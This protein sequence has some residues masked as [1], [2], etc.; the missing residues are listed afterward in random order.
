VENELYLVDTLRIPK[1]SPAGL[2]LAG[3][4]IWLNDYASGELYQISIE[5]GEI[6]NSL[7]CPGVISGLTWDG[8][9]LWQTRMDEDWLQRINPETLDFDLTLPLSEG[10]RLT[11]VAWDGLQL[12]VILQAKGT[13]FAIDAESGNSNKSIQVPVATTAIDIDNGYIWIRY[14]DKMKHDSRADNFTWVSKERTFKLAQLSPKNGQF[15]AHYR[16][17]FLPTGLA[18]HEDHIWLSDSRKGIIGI[19]AMTA[20]LD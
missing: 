2:A 18:W 15:L 9:N 12:W 14:P 1:S 13:L 19:Y 3:Q 5:N 17:E 20:H 8:R 16:L 7:R 6:V 11:D 4:Y 10:S